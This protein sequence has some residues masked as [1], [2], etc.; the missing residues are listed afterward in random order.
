[1]TTATH[2]YGWLMPDPGGSANTWGNTLNGTT[3]AIDAKMQT[4]NNQ[5]GPSTLSTSRGPD[6]GAY[7]ELAF[8][9]NGTTQVRWILG[10]S[11]ETESAGGNA[12]SNLFLNAYDNTGA[13]LGN[14]FEAYRGNQAVSF[15]QAVT[16]AGAFGVGG[17]VTVD[18]N[19]T[20]GALSANGIVS[21]SG[22]I[23]AQAT[24]GGDALIE[25]TDSTSALQGYLRWNHTNNALNLGN[26]NGAGAL[27]ITSDGWARANGPFA[28]GG[29]LWAYSGNVHAQA[30]GGSNATYWLV[31]NS[32]ANVGAVYYSAANGQTVLQ[33]LTHGAS[34]FVDA[35][36][37]FTFNGSG[38]AFKAGGGAWTATSDAR[39]KNVTGPYSAGLDEIAKLNPVRFTYKG[40]DGDAHALVKGKQFVGLVADEAMRAMPE[41]VSLREGEI[42]GR[43]VNDLKML[44]PTALIYAL[45]NS[46]KQL[47]AEIEAL[48]EGR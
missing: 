40:N 27:S 19:L 26:Q 10:E 47:K 13:F 43:K 39:I 37:N 32:G 16:V 41:L 8:W 6:G 31:N 3:Q 4:I 42:D 1:M 7:G 44:D 12:G 33:E 45:V 5:V 14:V 29:D 18:G 48:K 23:V 9:N 46:V 38:N 22:G 24:A 20:S 15:A 35:A 21:I 28:V 11:S 25:L 17:S 30:V 2:N 34:V 36:T